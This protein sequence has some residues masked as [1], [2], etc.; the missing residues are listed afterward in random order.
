MDNA[1][2]V[3]ITDPFLVRTAK[4][5]FDYNNASPR[6]QYKGTTYKLAGPQLP[7]NSLIIDVFYEV[8]SY[9]Q[10]DLT[11]LKLDL[12]STAG[13]TVN[14]RADVSVSSTSFNGSTSSTSSPAAIPR[15]VHEPIPSHPVPRT[16]S[17]SEMFVTIGGHDVTQGKFHVYI[18]YIISAQ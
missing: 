13:F 18:K 8:V 1:G 2:V 6:P 11:Q 4:Y 15:I 3:K 16:T 7:I 10:P 5:T 9:V 14:V 17:L 12:G